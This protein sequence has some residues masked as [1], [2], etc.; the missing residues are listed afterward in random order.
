MSASSLI[1]SA[2]MWRAPSSA[3]STLATPFSG[4]T[5]VGGECLQ[6]VAGRLLSPEIGGERLQAFFAGDRG[7]GAA[8][9]L[10]GQ[11]EIFQFA[12]VERG[13]DAGLQLVGQLALLG[14][15]GQDGLAA[16]HQLAEVAE[17]LFDV[18]DLDLVE[19]AGGFLAVAGDEG[20][21]AALVEQSDHGDEALHGD[22]KHAGNVHQKIGR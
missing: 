21:G 15:G 11:I 2:T 1:V 7:L 22:L 6:R 16:S 20:H 10:V 4:S 8:L 9:G 12:L 17:L 18:A 14:D 3:S 5:K 13:L 19:V